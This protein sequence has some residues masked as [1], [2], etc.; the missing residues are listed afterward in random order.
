MEKHEWVNAEVFMLKKFY[1]LL[2]YEV[3]Y[4]RN[5]IASFQI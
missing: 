5:R 2:G 4:E 1:A 3:S